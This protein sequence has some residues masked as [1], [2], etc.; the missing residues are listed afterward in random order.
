MRVSHWNAA[1]RRFEQGKGLDAG[2]GKGNTGKGAGGEP[3]FGGKGASGDVASLPAAAPPILP[4]VAEPV[5]APEM[6]G[7]SGGDVHGVSLEC[8]ICRNTKPYADFHK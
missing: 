1:Y 8:T 2:K 7:S 6:P 4:P 3:A 5:A